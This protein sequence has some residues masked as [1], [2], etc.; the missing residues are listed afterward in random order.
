MVL[1]LIVKLKSH[2]MTAG[3]CS[4]G[5]G[6]WE[7]QGAWLLSLRLDQHAGWDVGESGD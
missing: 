3:V 4:L 1:M 5:T 6:V 2:F 7:W